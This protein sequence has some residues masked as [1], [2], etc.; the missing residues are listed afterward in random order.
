MIEWIALAI[1]ILMFYLLMR[2][3]KPRNVQAD[4][5]EDSRVPRR[6]K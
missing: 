2:I 3:G 6:K 1:F 4:K 5:S